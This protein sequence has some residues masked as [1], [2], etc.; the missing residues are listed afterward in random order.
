MILE[1]PRARPTRQGFCCYGLGC[2]G[3][4]RTLYAAYMDWLNECGLFPYD[5]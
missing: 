2:E 4:G 5:V 1:K 3:H